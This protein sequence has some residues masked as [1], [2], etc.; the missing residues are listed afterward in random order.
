MKLVKNDNRERPEAE[1]LIAEHPEQEKQT[2]RN[3][4]MPSCGRKTSEV[5]DKAQKKRGETYN[6]ELVKSQGE[7]TRV[8]EEKQIQS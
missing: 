1:G 2:H 5:D 3:Q 7:D 8:G 6:N 4:E